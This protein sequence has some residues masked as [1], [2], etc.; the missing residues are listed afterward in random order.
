MSYDLR[1]SVKVEGIDRYIG[2]ATPEPDC[3]TYNLGDM[4][5]ACMNWDYEQGEYYRCSEIMTN[6]KYGI[7]ELTH[8][9]KDYEK[10]NP[11]NGW[12]NIDNALET[13]I[14]IRQCIYEEA[15]RIPIEHIC[16]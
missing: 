8:N 9:R 3:P 7:Y 1:I 10:Y 4:F 15:K 14:S 2:I 12:G 16:I 5:R 11:A 13:L 6:I